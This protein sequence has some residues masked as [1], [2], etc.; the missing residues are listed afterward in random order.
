MNKCDIDAGI[1]CAHL[2]VQRVHVPPQA[3]TVLHELVQSPSSPDAPVLLLPQREFWMFKLHPLP[4]GPGVV[5]EPLVL[6]VTLRHV[7]SL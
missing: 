1:D 4:G 3:L 6:D 2:F 5:Q 7:P